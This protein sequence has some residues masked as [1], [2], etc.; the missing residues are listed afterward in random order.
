MGAEP[1]GRNRQPGGAGEASPE[2]RSHKAKSKAGREDTPFGASGSGPGTPNRFGA[3]SAGLETPAR[4]QG[5]GDNTPFGSTDTAEPTG[6]GEVGAFPPDMGV[7]DWLSVDRMDT[8]TGAGPHFTS[9]PGGKAGQPPEPTQREIN[10]LEM[11][12]VITGTLDLAAG[13]II[14]PFAS[15][16][17][18]DRAAIEQ[19]LA[20]VMEQSAAYSAFS[21]YSAPVALAG[22][23]AVWSI[24]VA[25][26][27]KLLHPTRQRVPKEERPRAGEPV[28][29][30][31][32]AFSQNG[33]TQ[34]QPQSPVAGP[35]PMAPTP[36]PDSPPGASR[37][38][39]LSERMGL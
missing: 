22:A 32:G 17:E 27:W 6:P 33:S 1:T 39:D 29:R 20:K 28:R 36:P 14:G 30:D 7:I 11:A 3:S 10:S 37:V 38:S 19:S 13:T 34:P 16:T 15:M 35:P 2:K 5:S 21:K 9:M 4:S 18:L 31:A 25:I 8:P 26:M 23:L 24:R 12:S